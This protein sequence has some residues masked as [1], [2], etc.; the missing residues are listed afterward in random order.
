MGYLRQHQVD[1]IESE[2]DVIERTLTQRDVQDRGNLQA[3]IKRIDKQIE[4]QA[5]P[6]LTGEERDQKVRECQEIEARLVPFMPSDEEMRR[7]PA[8]T[9]GRH[10]KFDKA[11][12]SRKYFKEGDIS[13]WKDNQLALNKGDDDPDVANFERLRP[14]HNQASMLGAQISGQQYHNTNP[15]QAYLDG[16][17][18]TFG[19]QPAEAELGSELDEP[20]VERKPVRRKKATHRKKMAAK[21]SVKMTALACGR[22]MGPSG[23]HFHVAKCKICK[24]AVKE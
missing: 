1:E 21:K 18:R 14:L 8:G 12:K 22:M 20:E 6:N 4:D 11:A 10:N 17:D 15:S 9:V 24:A 23:R 5:P 3:H 2:R 13:R 19:T 7:N 16:H